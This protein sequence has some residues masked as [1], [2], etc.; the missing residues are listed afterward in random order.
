MST[1]IARAPR[2]VA[3]FFALAFVV[4]TCVFP[5]IASVNN[6]NENV[7][8]YMT[9]A[10]VEHHTLRIDAIVERQG[11]TNDM[12]RAPDPKK[13]EEFHLYSV[14]A[15]AVSYAG[16]P[17]YWAFTK[18]APR[19]GHP[20][21]TNASTPA[22]REWWLRAS[23]V[24]V[25]LFAV[26]LPCFLFLMWFERWLRL[27]TPDVVLRLSAV[28][29]VGLG[30]NYLAYSLMFASH[31]LFAVAAFG[32]FAITLREQM[33]HPIRRRRMS[34]WAAFASGFLAGMAT[35]LEYHAGP[36]SAALGFFALF[37]F[38]RPTRLIAFGFGAAINAAI[39]GFFQW[40]AF[41]S[42]LTP[43]HRMSENQ[44]FA[45]LLNQGYMGIGTPNGQVASELTF[46]HTFGFLG[47]SPFMWLAVLAIPFALFSTFG[48]KAERR[49]RRLAT[50]RWILIMAVLWTTV[51]AAINW[52]GGWTVGPRYLGAA[53]PFFA[54]GA[55][56]ALERFSG[57][58]RFRRAVARGLA[59]GLAL[60]GIAQIGFVSI[61]YN[62]IP[63]SV[64]RPFAQFALP[65]ARAGFVPHHVGELFGWM[66]P[67]FFYA[68]AGCLFAAGLVAALVPSRDRWWSFAT[69]VIVFGG[70]LFLGMRPAFGTPTPEEGGDLGSW[71]RISAARGWEP[72][73]RDRITT[74]RIEAE[75]FGPRRPCLW[76]KVAD[77]ERLVDW[78]TEADQD[79]KR[80]GKPRASCK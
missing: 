62:T 50:L 63:E 47:T 21:P 44:A 23:T 65:M 35:L 10:L 27:T 46:S 28:A 25:R 56:C 30:T 43:G 41:G 11:W 64:T 38:W 49:T 59:G 20:V 61:H 42:P 52:R 6:P 15:P 70:A 16:V 69:R 17:P 32:S 79:E 37:T 57:K 77:L 48:K 72:P 18:I 68:V 66:S 55:V 8:T 3:V 53:P 76:F 34:L 73:G 36:V 80:A 2:C 71:Q 4:Y 26:Q 5:Y 7:R 40:R 14:K 51:S 67:W 58:S 1:R 54:F 9:M 29:A 45:A 75:R 31:A 22:E 13:P 12:A 24:V 78:T 19:F 74:L 60:A 39:L 33:L